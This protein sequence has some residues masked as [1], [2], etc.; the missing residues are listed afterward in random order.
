MLEGQRTAEG[1]TLRRCAACGT[2]SLADPDRVPAARELYETGVYAPAADGR[3]GWLEPARRLLDRERLRMLGPL[4]PGARVIEVGAG[5]GRLVAAL[6]ARG[7]DAVGIEPSRAFSTAARA[8]GLP[9]EPL[10][11]EKAKYPHESADLVAFWHVLEHLHRPDEAIARAGRWLK[12][13]GRL[14][15]AVPNLGSLQARIGGDRWFHQDVPRHRTLFTVPGLTALLR[16]L[17][18][19]P[20]RVRHVMIDQNWL[21]MWL[22]LLNGLTA[23]RDVPYRFAK[24]DLRYRSRAA[25][26]RD[27]IVCAALGVPAMLAAPL[28]E[29]GAG[30][31]RSGGTI[32]VHASAWTR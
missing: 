31:T 25:A 29:L 4:R 20:T 26:V 18:F 17:D 16:R 28:L 19:A 14:V 9:V 13:D 1:W 3:D 8:R 30:V 10:A 32:V 24:R 7:H 5:R 22:T 2:A 15:I 11:L 23:G 21:G 12:G 27:A 6:R